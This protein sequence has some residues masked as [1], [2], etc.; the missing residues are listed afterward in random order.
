[1]MRRFGLFL[2]VALLWSVA[3]TRDAFDAWVNETE[4]PSVLA[5]TSVE[6][7]DRDGRL[8]R[9]YTV[10][11]GRWRFSV[12]L[13]EI[14]PKLVNML[15][16]YE[17]KRFWEHP[18]VDVIAMSRALYQALRYGR[19]VS[20]GSTLTMQVARLLE[21]SGTG[22]LA[23]KLRQARLA[24]AMERKLT[25]R[26]ILTL[27]FTHAPYGGNLEGVRAAALGY[28]GKEP[29]RLT[30]AEAALLVALP[31]SPEGRR[32]DKRHAR[33]VAARDRVLDRMHRAGAINSETASV[34]KREAIPDRRRD[35]PVLAPHIADRARQEAPFLRVHDLTIDRDLQARLEKLAAR[36]VRGKG[37]HLSIGIVVAD[38]VTGQVLASVGSAGITEGEQRDGF[39]DMTR[40]LRSPGSTLKPLVYALAF[41]RSLA[42]PQTLI[43]D[44]PVRF[45]AYAPENF[46]RQ[47]RGEVTVERA[48]QMSLNIPVVRLTEALGPAHLM[49]A[50]RRSGADPVLRGGAP[51]LAV[52]LGG[53][54][55]TLEDM[56]QLYASLAQMGK[57]RPIHWRKGAA[58]EQKHDVTGE[59]AAWQVS[60]ILASLSPPPGAPRDW[61]AYKTGT[62]YG[63]RDAW[64]IGY[65]GRHVAGV[66]IGRPDGTPVPGVFGGKVAAPVLFEAFQLLKTVPDALPPPPPATLILRN[67]DLPQPLKRFRAPNS[68]FRQDATALEMS[69]P[70]DGAVLSGDRV[71][72]KLR[73]GTPPFTVLVDGAPA[74]T[75]ARGRVLPVVLPSVGFS[76][77][78][79]IDAKGRSA[80]AMIRRE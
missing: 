50:L 71:T 6:V 57:A 19:V 42:H 29:N 73:H 67:A 8:L 18:G 46:D 64:S 34:S 69:F 62:S 13:D 58:S 4:L 32:P 72:L 31:Q 63:H 22:A 51:G 79:V 44:S 2:L 15:I 9:G 77:L 68:Q 43:D 55:L 41:D 24:L 12:T 53:V 52:A 30:T 80:S 65:D 75:N 10:E 33:A 11:D 25:K 27:Y 66:W 78:A 49:A 60:H 39:V 36:A 61:L 40:A 23:G 1:M 35:Y 26:E 45:G 5:E 70:P 47:F 14:D 37:D 17:D 28:F 21:D 16:A 3:V 38:H 48:L 20:G 7:L 59:I 56:V 54:G 74:L 76:R